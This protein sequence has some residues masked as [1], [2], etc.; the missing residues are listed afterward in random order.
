MICDTH[1]LTR[2]ALVNALVFA[3]SAEQAIVAANGLVEA[4][5]VTGNPWALSYALL[6]V[7]F[8]YREAD[9]ARALDAARRGLATARDSGNR[10]NESH[11]ASL[12]SSLEIE[13]GDPLAAL[14]YITLAIRNYHDS[15]SVAFLHSPLINLAII[16]DRV[17]HFA[18]AAVVV[19]FAALNPLAVVSN[20]QIAAIIN[21]IREN[22]GPQ[23]YDALVREGAT[24][25]PAAMV[26]YA[27]E[28]IDQARA[29][30]GR[31]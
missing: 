11:L 6:S 2:S 13:C 26:T 15:G 17:G 14:D 25:T 16:L 30:L 31:R 28:Q 12:L 18:G 27:Y 23:A 19:S 5:E 1:G 29:E 9:P 4:A 10:F 21:H 20:P 22:L 7:G 8:A 3:G 24:M